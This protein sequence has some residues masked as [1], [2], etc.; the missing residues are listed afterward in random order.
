MTTL[1][2]PFCKHSNQIYNFNIL[3]IVNIIYHIYTETELYQLA[4]VIDHNYHHKMI[5]LGKM[6]KWKYHDTL[7]K[8]L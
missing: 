5:F 3:R 8:G 6:D 7:K 2:I 1:L 4:H